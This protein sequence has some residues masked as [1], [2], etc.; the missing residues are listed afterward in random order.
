MPIVQVNGLYKPVAKKV[1]PVN[2]GESSGDTLG[3]LEN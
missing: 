1:R 3:G 2:L